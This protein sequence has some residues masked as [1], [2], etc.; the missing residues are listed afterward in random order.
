MTESLNK[1]LV[2]AGWLLVAFL[3]AQTLATLTG[4]RYIGAGIAPADTIQVSGHGEIQAAP[5]LA[6]V[7]FSVVSDKPTAQAAQ[8]DAAQ[9]QAAVSAYLKQAGIAEVDI[10]TSGYS[11]YPQYS[12][13]NAVCPQPMPLTSG[14]ASSQPTVYCPPGKQVLTGYEASQSTTVKIRDL[15][16]VGDVLAGVG[17]AGATEISS[18]TFTFD[19]PNAPQNEARQAAIADAKQKAEELAKELGVSLVRV[20][21][22]SENGSG[23]PRP[24]MYAASAAGASTKSSA[25]QINPG[26]NT[27]TD[28]VT[29]TYEIR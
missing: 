7:T 23:Y 12:Y 4:I 14:A 6:E 13:Q 19:D 3:A 5:T 10:Q 1:A 22:F 21:S 18:P 25:P 15:A 26:Q 9:K 17:Q 20:V 11:V 16:K 27:V 28:D 2:T 8:S 24:M 29:V